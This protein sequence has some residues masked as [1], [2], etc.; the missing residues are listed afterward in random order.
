MLG[1]PRITLETVD[2]ETPASA[3]T[4]MIVAGRRAPTS[5]EG[6]TASRVVRGACTF[7]NVTRELPDRSTI[8]AFM[9]NSDR[10]DVLL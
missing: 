4:W 3:A 10:P 6:A 7:W 5:A 2:F 9:T 8:P 1:A